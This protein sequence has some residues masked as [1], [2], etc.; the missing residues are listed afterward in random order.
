MTL[1][2]ALFPWA[3]LLLATI[4]A[5]A[6]AG[7]YRHKALAVDIGDWRAAHHAIYAAENLIAV[8][9][10]NPQADDGYKGPIITRARAEILRLQ[11]ALGRPQWRW[12]TPCCYSR[13]PIYIR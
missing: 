7:Q 3:A 6:S 4:A 2:H 5:P 10:A 12:P 8:L 13:R 11:A 9:Q 1:R